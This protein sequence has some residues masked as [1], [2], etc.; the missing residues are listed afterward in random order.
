MKR[1]VIS[2]DDL[3]SNAGERNDFPVS[4]GP[5]STIENHFA[6]KCLFLP[7]ISLSEEKTTKEGMCHTRNPNNRNSLV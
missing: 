2:D 4:N 5:C 1:F 6:E 3:L 7:V